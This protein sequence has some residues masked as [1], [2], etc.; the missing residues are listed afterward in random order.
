MAKVETSNQDRT[1]SL[2]SAVRSYRKLDTKNKWVI[3]MGEF[4]NSG[5]DWE[6]E[7]PLPNVSI[8]FY[9]YF[10]LFVLDKHKTF[11]L[12]ITHTAYPGFN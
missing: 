11:R 5:F 4:D 8:L 9:N 10:L 6:C 1:I 3:L 12:T 2:K 7:L